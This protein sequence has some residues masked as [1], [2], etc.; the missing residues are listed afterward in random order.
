[1]NDISSRGREQR[2]WMGNNEY[3][4]SGKFP[5]LKD[6]NL[7]IERAHQMPS[8]MAYHGFSETQK[9]KDTQISKNILS[10]TI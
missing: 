4:N 1:M 8:R 6:M 9:R 7:D 2:K 5:R 10:C 3:N